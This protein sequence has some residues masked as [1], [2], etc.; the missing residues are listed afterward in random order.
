MKFEIFVSS[1][2]RDLNPKFMTFRY[3]MELFKT[4]IKI[5]VKITS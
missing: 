2:P 5:R 1:F 3:R 4:I